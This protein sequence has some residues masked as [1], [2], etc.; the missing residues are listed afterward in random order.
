M[1]RVLGP[2]MPGVPPPQLAAQGRVMP[3]SRIRRGPVSPGRRAGWERGGGARAAPGPRARGVPSRIPKKSWSREAIHGG[4]PDVVHR[5]RASAGER[6]AFGE[7]AVEDGGP[8]PG[9]SVAEQLR[10]WI[11]LPTSARLLRPRASTARPARRRPARAQRASGN[12]GARRL[13]AGSPSAVQPVGVHRRGEP[14]RAEG[15]REDASTASEGSAG[16]R[17]ASSRFTAP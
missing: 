4:C 5:Y 13:P 11:R 3:A 17:R 16:V 9:D 15:V 1:E 14:A 6:D 7:L 2:G 10:G 12:I 8:T